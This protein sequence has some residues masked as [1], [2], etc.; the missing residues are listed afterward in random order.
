MFCV[1]YFYYITQNSKFDFS[2]RNMIKIWR[3]VFNLLQSEYNTSSFT[4]PYIKVVVKKK[5]NVYS[6]AKFLKKQRPN[7]IG[8]Y[9]AAKL[10]RRLLQNYIYDSSLNI[11]IFRFHTYMRSFGC[12]PESGDMSVKIRSIKATIVQNYSHP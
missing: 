12:A 10:E 2:Q 9:S 11:F 4:D 1:M 6:A 8:L 5:R 3:W 7:N